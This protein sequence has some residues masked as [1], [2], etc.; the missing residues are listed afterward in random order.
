M[1]II[2]CDR[3]LT[4]D[5]LADLKRV[6]RAAQTDPGSVLVLPKGIRVRQMNGDL[7]PV[8]VA[9]PGQRQIDLDDL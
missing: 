5:E 2:E 6:W 1:T 3:P 7:H 9:Q 8:F 4:A